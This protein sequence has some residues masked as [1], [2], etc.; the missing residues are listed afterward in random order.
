[1]LFN[2]ICGIIYYFTIMKNLKKIRLHEGDQILNDLQLKKIVVGIYVPPGGSYTPPEQPGGGGPTDYCS[3]M[4][5]VHNPAL[6][7][8]ECWGGCRCDAAHVGCVRW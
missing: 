3:T 4:K 8:D 6:G 7:Y 2:K 1:M 5:C